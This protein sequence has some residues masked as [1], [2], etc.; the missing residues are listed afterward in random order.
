MLVVALLL[1]EQLFIMALHKPTDLQRTVFVFG[2][3][4]L[5]TVNANT[6]A[7]LL[8]A[9][10]TVGKLAI[11]NVATKLFWA[12]SVAVALV[13]GAPLELLALA[14]LLSESL[15]CLVNFIVARK[16]LELELVIDG[17]ATRRALR[18][19]LPFYINST[20]VLLYAKIDVTIM[21]MQLPDEE[22][23][24]YGTATSIAGIT[25]ILTPLFSS[26]LMPQLARA[27]TK[28]TDELYSMLRRSLELLCVISIP[29]SL[30][31]GLGA[32]LAIGTIFGPPFVPAALAL[33][34]LSPIFVLTYVAMLGSTCLVLTGRGWTATTISILS[35]FLNATLN[36]FLLRPGMRLFGHGGGGTTAAALSVFTEL[37]VSC[38]FLIAMGRG[39]FDRKNVLILLKC[40][41][42]CIVAIGCHVLFAPLGAARLIVDVIAYGV[43]VVVTGAVEPRSFARTIHQA[44]VTRNSPSGLAT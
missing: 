9:A 18:A 16:R 4:Q 41:L 19:A 25:F 32:D 21:A 35:I 30:A 39:V 11:L 15:R 2:I 5:A 14:F 37:V 17:A 38:A 13:I 12:S 23:G 40:A 3:A 31:T 44:W 33:R 10:R 26:V 6:F 42:G 29:I 1:G 36:Q 8:H 7:T 34:V 24:W 27:V 43:V 22:V 20:A 28:G